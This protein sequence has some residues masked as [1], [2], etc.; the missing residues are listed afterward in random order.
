[1]TAS[2]TVTCPADGRVVGS[3]VDMDSAAVRQRLAR[4]REAQVGWEKIG[5]RARARWL[6]WWREWLLD[7]QQSLADVLQSETAKPRAEAGLEPLLAADMINYFAGHAVEFL[8][9][10]ARRPH[11]PLGLTKRLMTV[12]RPYPVVGVITPWN[13]PLAM[14]VMDAAPALVAG[15]AVALKPSEVTPLS[16]LELQRGWAEIGAPAVFDVLTG[17]SNAG[18]AVVDHADFIQFTGSTRTGRVIAARAA[19]RL[20]PYSLELGGKDPAIV[21]A[22]A[23]I[24]RAVEGVMWG[25]LFNAGQVCVSIERVY[26]EAPIYNEFVT[27]LAERMREL[28]QGP[29]DRDCRFDIGPLAT[30][31]QRDIVAHHVADAIERGATAAVGGAPGVSGTFFEPTVLVDVDH[32][33]ACMREETFGPTIPVMKVGD[34]DE[35]IHLANQSNYGLSATI[36]T[37][38]VARGVELA[39]RLEAGAVNVNDAMSNLFN[40]TLPHS[41]W[42][43][44]GVGARFGGA[45]GVRKYTRQQAIT[46]PR[47]QVAERELLW[48]PYTAERHK[49]AVRILRLITGRG[50]ARILPARRGPRG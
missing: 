3:I 7:H 43:E 25:G 39:R 40:F 9:D 17:G 34:A 11:G 21:L 32:S 22:D 29:D 30:P 13:F 27:R 28:R 26:V 2:L 37:A 48:Y 10:G 23:D 45:D 36:W 4:L 12:Y 24:D 33:M 20:I 41:G 14:P 50:V 19:S 42:K 6:S 5:P 35:A 46:V 38:N 47:V 15:A 16:A 49:L 8:R 1:M 44:S 18:A 31:A